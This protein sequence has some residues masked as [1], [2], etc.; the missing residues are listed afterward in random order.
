MGRGKDYENEIAKELYRDTGSLVKV[1]TAGYSGNN[2]IPQPDIHVFDNGNTMA[3]D[4]ELKTA[5]TDYCAIEEDDLQ[6][7]VECRAP[8]TR[9]WLHVKF[10]R[11]APLVVPFVKVTGSHLNHQPEQTRVAGLEVTGEDFDSIAAQ[12][13]HIINQS[14]DEA[15]DARVRTSDGGITRLYLTKPDTDGWPSASASE[16]DHIEMANQMGLRL[17][18]SSPVDDSTESSMTDSE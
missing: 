16:D 12:F 2:A 15:F 14:T 3:H 13:A 8:N 6:Q 5:Q 7:L 18:D 4:I 9:V 17:K 1:Y 10:S 11:R